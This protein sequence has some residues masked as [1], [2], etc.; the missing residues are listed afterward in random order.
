M[1][2]RTHPL[3][4]AGVIALT[5][6]AFLSAVILVN[7][8]TA[9]ESQ[10]NPATQ[11]LPD[12]PAALANLRAQAEALHDQ[13]VEEARLNGPTPELPE[14]VRQPWIEAWNEMRSCALSHGYDGVPAVQPTFGDGKTPLPVIS[15][16]EN[17][18]DLPAV[19]PLDLSGVDVEALKAA[20]IA[21]SLSDAAT[22][23]G[24]QSPIEVEPVE[25]SQ[26]LIAEAEKALQANDPAL[27]N[28]FTTAEAR[29]AFIRSQLSGR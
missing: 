5:L 27:Y 21:D 6:G 1:N 26:E 14:H 29:E 2:V 22:N 4:V 13:F 3:R 11:D 8:R 20:M 7:S 23:T 18:E 9:A 10:A 17:N 16:G 28:S 24:Q 15:I 19:C 25:P 12:D